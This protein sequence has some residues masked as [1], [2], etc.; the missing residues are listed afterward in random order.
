MLF[1]SSASATHQAYNSISIKPSYEFKPKNWP[2]PET[3]LNGLNGAGSA[4][5]HWPH[6]VSLKD[7]SKQ[8]DYYPGVNDI[9]IMYI[10]N[11]PITK[12]STNYLLENGPYESTGT[13]A[14]NP[15]ICEC[16]Q[17]STRSCVSCA[18][19]SP[20]YC[21]CNPIHSKN[22]SAAIQNIS[23]SERMCGF[24]VYK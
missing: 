4:G 6:F 22:G 20:S 21:G 17:R 13:L 2:L 12:L 14:P 15:T 1:R 3:P 7:R 5:V 24:G 19:S 10:S 16:W 18:P 9:M 23:F 8:Y 11:A